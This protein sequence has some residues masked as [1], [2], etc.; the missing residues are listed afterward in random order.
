MAHRT[1]T[2]FEL[3][4]SDTYGKVFRVGRLARRSAS[5]LPVEG[6]RMHDVNGLRVRNEQLQPV[7]LGPLERSDFVLEA[8]ALLGPAMQ[9]DARSWTGSS[10]RG[11]CR[12]ERP[13]GTDFDAGSAL[14][15]L[16]R[17]Y[18]NGKITVPAM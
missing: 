10:T 2:Q 11:R 1:H 6:P 16:P 4:T 5:D 12:R 7:R 17:S 9:G 3:T 8:R 18:R 13:V 15:A 14:R